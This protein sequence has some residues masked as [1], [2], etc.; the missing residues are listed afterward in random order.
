MIIGVAALLLLLA[1][2]LTGGSLRQ[3][4]EIPVRAWWLLPAALLLQVLLFS[5]LTKVP[6]WLGFS[7]HLLSY[8]LAGAFIWANRALRGLPLIALGAGLNAVT[9]ALNGGT[10]PAS[11]SAVRTAG[12]ADSEHFSN[13]GVLSDPRLPWLGD[14]FAVPSGVPFA[15]V[16]SIGDVVILTGVAVLVFGHSRVHRPV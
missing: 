6:D 11:E 9:I 14:V 3:L 7:L 12:L 1:V 8:M 2:P 16:F 13:S 10:L 4:G 15:N 5:V